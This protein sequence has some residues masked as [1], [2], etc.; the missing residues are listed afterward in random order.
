MHGVFPSNHANSASSRRIQFH[1]VDVGDSGEI[2]T[3]FMQVGTYPTRNFAQYCYYRSL[4]E[5]FKARQPFV[6]PLNAIAL[7]TFQSQRTI[8]HADSLLSWSV[9]NKWT[10]WEVERVLILLRILQCKSRFLICV[11]RVDHFCQPLHVAMQLGLYLQLDRFNSNASCL[12][13]SLWGSVIW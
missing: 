6:Q 11:R 13:Y 4:Q 8:R 12:A 3:P 9:S 1:W 5:R 7:Q 10:T 2:V